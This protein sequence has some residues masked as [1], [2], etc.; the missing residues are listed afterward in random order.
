M[1]SEFTPAP[2]AK[3]LL[4]RCHFFI[5]EMRKTEHS[6]D[7]QEEHRE[8]QV[9]R[10]SLRGSNRKPAETQGGSSVDAASHHISVGDFLTTGACSSQ[11]DA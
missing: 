10:I 6:S 4:Y 11:F 9:H 5:A 3:L 8:L 7:K 2:G 1:P